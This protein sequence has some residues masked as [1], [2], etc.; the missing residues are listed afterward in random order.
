MVED[1]YSGKAEVWSVSEGTAG[2][3][4]W[5]RCGIR[6]VNVAGKQQWLSHEK[7]ETGN[8]FILK[9]YHQSLSHDFK[10]AERKNSKPH[11]IGNLVLSHVMG[12]YLLCEKN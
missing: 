3:V 2:E 8:K 7:L 1:G 5:K 6:K 11:L 10:K 12:P 4:E 9:V